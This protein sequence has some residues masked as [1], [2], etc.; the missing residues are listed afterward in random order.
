MI[1]LY[2]QQQD[3]RFMIRGILCVGSRSFEEL[4]NSWKNSINGTD[5]KLHKIDVGEEK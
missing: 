3:R 4:E 2:Q 5:C 1:G